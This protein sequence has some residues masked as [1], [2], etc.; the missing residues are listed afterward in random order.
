M[1]GQSRSDGDESGGNG[2]KCRFV[3]STV[4]GDRGRRLY[5][6]SDFGF[7]SITTQQLVARLD[8]LDIGSPIDM[9]VRLILQELKSAPKAVY[10][11]GTGP[12]LC[13]IDRQMFVYSV[14]RT[15][16]IATWSRYELPFTVDVMDEL[17]RGLYGVDLVIQGE[18]CFSM[19]FDVRN[20]EAITDEVR[21]VSNTYGGG[22]IPLEVTC[23]EFAPRFWNVTGGP[24]QLDA[25]TIYYEPL[26]VL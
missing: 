6:L 4:A 14:S 17:D 7:R 3:L 20:V 23:T 19:R 15:S 5:V 25:L 16:K 12:Y 26:G 10:F 8:D 11:Y 9:P 13:A 2:R 21:V 22:L 1:G 24:F 18:C